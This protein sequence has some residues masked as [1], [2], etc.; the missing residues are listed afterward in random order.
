MKRKI[1]WATTVIA[2]SAMTGCAVGPTY[3]QPDLALPSAWV[4]PVP[5]EG[6]AAK[7]KDWWASWG[8]LVLLDLIE[9]AQKENAT[10]SVAAA[11]ID[12]AR[13]TVTSVAAPLWPSADAKANDNRSRS[14]QGGG[15]DQFANG[16][17]G[18]GG[19]AGISR[20]RSASIDALWELDL[21]GGV[22]RNK[23]AASARA[24]AR[25]IDWHD[26]RVSVA[27]EVAT[28][29]VNLRACEILAT[30]YET[31][32]KSRAE[33][34]RL[35][36]LK[37]K[38]GFT[39][40]AEAALSNASASEAAAR[41]TQQRADCDVEV[42][43]LSLVSVTPEPQLRAKLAAK[44]A[45]FPAPAGWPLER[46]PASALLQ[47]P[48]VAAAERELAAAS[49]EIG[50]AEAD[51]YPRITLTGSISYGVSNFGGSDERGRTWSY[52]PS[53]SLPIFDAGRRAANVD[54]AKARYAEA[55]ATY[56]GRTARAVR[57]VE[58]SLVRISSATNRDADSKAALKGYQAFLTAADARVRVGAASQ[59][60]LEEARRSVVAA[61]GAVVNVERERL[62]S[63]IN[64]Y[65]SVGGGWSNASAEIAANVS[66]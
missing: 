64:L 60:E 39:A 26:A 43:A 66:K 4:A 16:G 23:E 8:D 9:N 30:G 22:R 56:K 2:A 29:Y 65:K 62:T 36:E 37:A 53:I 45:M 10:V 47:R 31:D 52:G 54:A 21:F 55:L 14:N 48:D 25:T 7:L 15:G 51:R 12:A 42:K 32:A 57:E 40:P 11:R 28:S 5:Q 61:Q 44:T 3:K 63:W 38:A 13:A 59:V 34:A 19:G 17:G 50:A 33:T 58:E 49:A 1:Q 6:K 20:N 24:E 35:T 41:L 18:S 27:A 46:V